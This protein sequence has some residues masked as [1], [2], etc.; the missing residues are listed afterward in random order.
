M[1]HAAFNLLL[2]GLL[3][4]CFEQ[5]TK[6]LIYEGTVCAKKEKEITHRP[7][8]VWY[9]ARL[10]GGLRSIL[11]SLKALCI[12]L[13]A[14][15]CLKGQSDRNV[16][17]YKVRTPV[18]ECT[19][20]WMSECFVDWRLW[21]VGQLQGTLLTA[22]CGS[23]ICLLLEGDEKG[24]SLLSSVRSPNLSS[25]QSVASPPPPPTHPPRTA[26]QTP[27]PISGPI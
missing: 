9:F 1:C 14:W 16:Q 4:S 8:Y 10:N 27:A 18:I 24:E 15:P 5:T 21:W 7:H 13:A 17:G 3:N 11:K 20:A 22:A 19:W 23:N 6:R 25:N 26:T 2:F 12:Q